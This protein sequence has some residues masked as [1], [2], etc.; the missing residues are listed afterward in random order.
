MRRISA[1]AVALAATVFL[2]GS[3]CGNEV[4][5]PNTT[6]TPIP[7]AASVSG[8]VTVGGTAFPN[9]PMTVESLSVPGLFKE[10]VTDAHGHYSIDGLAAG[11]AKG[12]V[13]TEEGWLVKTFT[14]A[15]GQNTYNFQWP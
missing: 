2:T 5:A 15:P 11:P 12:A 3:H 1:L 13:S 9:A 14:L 7:S 10:T 6:P 4:T 8:S